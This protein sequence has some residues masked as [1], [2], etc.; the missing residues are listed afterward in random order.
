MVWDMGC[1][2]GEFSETALSAGAKRVIGFDFDQTALE[3]AYRRAKDRKLA[4]LPLFQDAANPSPDH[5]WNGVERK[6]LSSRGN[7]DALIA[8]AFEHH[9]AIGRNIPLDQL[10]AWLVSLAPVGLVEF[11]PRGDSNLDRLL[12]HREDVFDDYTEDN[13]RSAIEAVAQVDR[14]DVVSAS[15]RKLYWYSRQA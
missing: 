6:S 3:T 8:L 15:G 12:R 7:A 9:L 1:N 5:G 14:V 10:I 11:V 4:F 2:T 13:F